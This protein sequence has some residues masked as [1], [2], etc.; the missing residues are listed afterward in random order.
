MALN[1]FVAIYAST[2]NQKIYFGTAAPTTG[3]FAAG[4]RVINTSLSTGNPVEWVCISAGTPGTWKAIYPVNDSGGTA[5]ASSSAATLSKR[6]GVITSEALT[7]AAGAA[8]TLTITNTLV[9]ATSIITCSVRNG[10]NTQGIPVVGVVTPG[11]GSFTVKVYN[12]HSSQALNGT[13]K[14]SFAIQ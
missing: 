2:I 6:S 11:S 1:E 9:A 3:T 14:V 12:L 13:V 8:E 7:T 5:S 4:D 10:T